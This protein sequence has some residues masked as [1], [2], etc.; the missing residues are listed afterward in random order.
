MATSQI[1]VARG[2]QATGLCLALVQACHG[3][4]GEMAVVDVSIG[5][6]GDTTGYRQPNLYLR[7]GN[8]LQRYAVAVSHDA[9]DC[10]IDREASQFEADVNQHGIHSIA[11]STQ[12]C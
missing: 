5:A 11:G 2:P 12:Q 7:I 9:P 6:S 8:G 10:G 3:N 1:L 4:G